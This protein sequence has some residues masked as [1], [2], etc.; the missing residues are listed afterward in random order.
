MLA[1]G[2]AAASDDTAAQTLTI[3]VTEAPREVR[4]ARNPGIDPTVTSVDFSTV[5]GQAVQPGTEDGLTRLSFR[6][7]AGEDLARIV[8][9]RTGDDLGQLHIEVAYDTASTSPEAVTAGLVLPTITPA[10]DGLSD[11]S[12]LR[13]TGTATQPVH[14]G[15]DQSGWNDAPQGALVFAIEAGV[16]L[17]GQ[18]VRWRL[19]GTAL[20]SDGDPFDLDGSGA[21]ALTS[22][23]TYV[24]DSHEPDAD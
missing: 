19:G 10:G 2:I 22:T 23:I 11:M 3:T 4:I 13:W 5:N 20:D 17:T 9:T 1:A 21:L 24:L 12:F 15:A 18:P 7:P 6:N 14:S 8:L 16:D